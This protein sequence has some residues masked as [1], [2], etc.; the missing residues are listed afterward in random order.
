MDRSVLPPRHVRTGLGSTLAAGQQVS[1]VLAGH[2]G[3]DPLWSSDHPA[4]P[5]VVGRVVLSGKT[6]LA[7]EV[8]SYLLEEAAR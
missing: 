4:G 7:L 8:L 2:L 3:Q 5:D 1:E 6:T